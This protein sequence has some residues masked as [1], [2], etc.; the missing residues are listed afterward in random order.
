[1]SKIILKSKE[2][3][4]LLRQSNI[5]VSKTIG[6]ISKHIKP[7]VKTIELDKMAEEFIRDN[8][9]IPGFKGYNNFPNTLC[10][11]INDEIVHGIPSYRE[12][13]EGD[14][15]TIDCGVIMNEFYGDSAYTFPV[16]K[17]KEEIKVFLKI[18]KE[19]LYKG[20]EKSVI[21]NRLGDIGFE[22]QRHNQHHGY[23]VIRDLCGHGVG[24]NLHEEPKVFNYG[25]KGNG[26]KLQE[27]MSIAIEPMV[28]MG[29]NY[30]I[31]YEGDH[32]IKTKDKSISCHFEHSIVITKEGPDI[33][34]TFK[35]IE[36]EITR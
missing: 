12:L 18:V 17:I 2:E 22:V 11:S 32:V 8:H 4:E 14:I 15:I 1:M 36:D 20:I 30:N 24:K 13:K 27:G 9:G 19:S 7:G 21:G 28:I 5:L 25:K 16:G 6:L 31:S 23:S 3:I 35:Y 26:I 34:S 10:T 33:L 29:S